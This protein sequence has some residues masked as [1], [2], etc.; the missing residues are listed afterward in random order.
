[1]GKRQGCEFVKTWRCS[2][3]NKYRTPQRGTA[4][5]LSNIPLYIYS[6]MRATWT[7]KDPCANGENGTRSFPG[8][9][10]WAP[11][12]GLSWSLVGCWRLEAAGCSCYQLPLLL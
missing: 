4:T 12:P 5:S 2:R 9:G 10:L 6:Q 8:P 1:M 3:P 7:R 11:G